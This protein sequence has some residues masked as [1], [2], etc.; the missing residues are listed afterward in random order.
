MNLA[1]TGPDKNTKKMLGRRQAFLFF[2]V[3]AAYFKSSYEVQV[4]AV[5]TE[6]FNNGGVN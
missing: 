4:C 3:L 5:G 2:L 6:R 1:G